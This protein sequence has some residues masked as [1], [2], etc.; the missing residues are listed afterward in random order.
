MFEYEITSNRV[1]CYSVLGIAR[2]AAATFGKEFKAPVITK[3]GNSEDINDYLK[4]NGRKYRPLQT[5]LRRMVKNIH[6][7]PSPKW[8]QHRLAASG[9]RPINNIVDITNYIMEEYG[10]LCTHMICGLSLAM[11]SLCAGRKKAKLL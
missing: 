4:G 1:D 5:L 8:L 2:E 11:R 10:Q 7:A 3:T 9:I 6:L